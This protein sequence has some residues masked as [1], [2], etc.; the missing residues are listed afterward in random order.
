MA[1]KTG[2]VVAPQYIS[3]PLNN[4]MTNY[5]VYYMS[6]PEKALYSV[7]VFLVG[8][9]VGW[10]FYG[11]LFKQEGLPTTATYISNAVVFTVVGLIAAKFFVPAIGDMLINKRN[12]ALQNQFMDL[13]EALST[14]LAAGNTMFGAVVNAR[15]DLLNQYSE[16]DLIIVELNEI[17][18]GMDNGKTLEEM[19][20]NFGERSGNEDI[21]NFGNVISNCYRLGGNFGD[22]V[23]RTRE[24]ISDKVAVADEIATKIASNKLQHNVMCIMPIVLVAMLKLSNPDFANNL[25]SALGVIVTTIA[26]AIFVASYFWG[27]KIINVG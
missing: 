5:A 8:G 22:V 21:K 13:L 6:L 9:C 14:S 19:L 3:S 2:K 25:S 24:I 17:V 18:A 12:K 16:T 20:R 23:R 10:V 7:L 15:T 26:I 27:Q 4:P 11:G 1:K